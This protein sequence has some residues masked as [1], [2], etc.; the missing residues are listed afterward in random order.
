MEPLS[1]F[2]VEA[3]TIEGLSPG[4]FTAA[5]NALLRSEWLI[6]RSRA[7]PF[8]WITEAMSRTVPSMSSSIAHEIQVGSHLGIQSGNSSLDR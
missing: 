5:V 3:R 4:Q 1:P 7:T 6:L 2:E 8:I